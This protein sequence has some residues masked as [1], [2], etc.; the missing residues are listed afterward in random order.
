MLLLDSMFLPHPMLLHLYQCFY[1]NFSDYHYLL[2]G[3]LPH[4]KHIPARALS[5]W[6]HLRLYRKKNSKKTG[7]YIINT[8]LN[9]RI[10][11]RRQDR[12]RICVKQ[13]VLLNIREEYLF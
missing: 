3:H 12:L 6:M 2:N 7:I 10:S 1:F 9:G 13:T 4:S 11:I 8:A 5:E